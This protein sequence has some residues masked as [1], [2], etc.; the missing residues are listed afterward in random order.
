MRQQRT[1]QGKVIDGLSYWKKLKS[2]LH[3]FSDINASKYKL[4]PKSILETIMALPEKTINGYGK[5]SMIEENHFLIQ[6]VRIP[7][8]EDPTFIKIIQLAYNYGQLQGSS[9]NIPHEYKKLGNIRTFITIKDIH[10]LDALIEQKNINIFRICDQITE[11]F[12]ND[13]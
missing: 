6:L 3:D 12:D 1:R 2:I 7:S 8:Q 11:M 9:N 4:I 10:A 13:L 5:I